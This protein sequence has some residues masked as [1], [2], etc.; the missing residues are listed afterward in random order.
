MDFVATKKLW[1]YYMSCECKTGLSNSGGGFYCPK[2]DITTQ[3]PIPRYR[4]ETKVEDDG[5]A[6]IFTLFGKEAEK[7]IGQSCGTLY[8]IEESNDKDDNGG[9]HILALIK[10]VI[11]IRHVF[12]VKATQYNK[13][14]KRQTFSV[15]RI[16]PHEILDN[17]D[18]K[19]YTFPSTGEEN[20]VTQEKSSETKGVVAKRNK[21]M[22]IDEEEETL[23]N[24]NRNGEATIIKRAKLK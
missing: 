15:S 14:A 9:P 23:P 3:E 10:N 7:L 11:G 12:Q 5:G 18:D 16:H 1:Y 17:K 4:I 6:I 2:C 22:I 20:G 21:S 8:D 24:T 13:K 19:V